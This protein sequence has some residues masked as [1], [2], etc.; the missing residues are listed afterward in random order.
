VLV[1]Y[2][3]RPWAQHNGMNGRRLTEF[4]EFRNGERYGHWHYRF[5]D[6]SES[7]GD[8]R[9]GQKN[10]VWTTRAADGATTRLE[11]LDGMPLGDVGGK[12]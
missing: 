9:N 10:G 6:G 8:Y 5:D 2:D 3:P 1:I 7:E 11:Y 4:G 12:Q